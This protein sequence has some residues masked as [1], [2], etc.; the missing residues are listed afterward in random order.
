MKFNNTKHT[1]HIY[2]WKIHV[3]ENLIYIS[4]GYFFSDILCILLILDIFSLR[5]MIR[6][7]F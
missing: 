1:I 2:N 4:P 5:T 7:L 6:I 3:K